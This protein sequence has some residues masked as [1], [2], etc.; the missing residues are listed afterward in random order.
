MGVEIYQ[1]A[2]CTSEVESVSHFTE[3]FFGCSI[4]LTKRV[5][6]DQSESSTFCNSKID[7]IELGES[8]ITLSDAKVGQSI[9][10]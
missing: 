10:S 4:L 8:K 5:C 1:S 2:G 3:T 9:T 7:L 6:C